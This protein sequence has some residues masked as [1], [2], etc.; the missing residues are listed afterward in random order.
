MKLRVGMEMGDEGVGGG[1]RE[2]RNKDD[3]GIEISMLCFLSEVA[4]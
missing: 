4:G 1:V 2:V 3:L